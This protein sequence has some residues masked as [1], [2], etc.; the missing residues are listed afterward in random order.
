MSLGGKRR[1]LVAIVFVS[2][3]K[4]LFH[5][6]FYPQIKAIKK[7][8]GENATEKSI[9]KTRLLL[10]IVTRTSHVFAGDFPQGREYKIRMNINIA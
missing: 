8:P 2:C 10:V 7:F 6:F 9:G 5:R 4:K 3:K 1:N